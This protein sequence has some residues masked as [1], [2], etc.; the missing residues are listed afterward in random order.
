MKPPQ[1]EEKKAPPPAKEQ[2]PQSFL[3]P[4]PE[5]KEELKRATDPNVNLPKEEKLFLEQLHNIKEENK[6][7]EGSID[8]SIFG[9]T[10]LRD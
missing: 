10:P 9:R 1:I 3:A 5:C 4:I 8:V 7:L 2:A 6:E